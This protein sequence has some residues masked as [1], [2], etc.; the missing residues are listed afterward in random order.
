MI[1]PGLTY[2]LR[3]AV[4]VALTNRALSVTLIESRGP[5]FV[6]PAS[7][8]FS[9]LPD[10]FEPSAAQACAAIDSRLG[11]AA[12]AGFASVVFGGVG[13][14]LVRL[15]TLL[16]VARHVRQLGG[17]DDVRV[18]TAGLVAHEEQADTAAALA[19]A[20]VT[21]ASV[22]LGSADAAQYAE[23]MRPR[24]ACGHEHVC[25][26]VRQLVQTGLHVTCTAVAAPGVD[27]QAARA[28]S[29]SLG[30]SDFKMRSYHP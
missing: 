6:M 5:G 28:L 10:G 21:S 14:P 26:F 20:G 22:S 23:L 25:A 17:V 4:Y 8:G 7:A 13:D 2:V 27:E 9:P 3:N 16:E 11:S 19:S 24:G 1:Q 29:E 15:P 18:T 30:A 12:E